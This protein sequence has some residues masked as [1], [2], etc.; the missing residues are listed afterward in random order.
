MTIIFTCKFM[1]SDME[2]SAKVNVQYMLEEERNEREKYF[3]DLVKRASDKVSLSCFKQFFT[4]ESGE[5]ILAIVRSF[6]SP[7]DESPGNHEV[8]F[9]LWIGNEEER[10]KYSKYVSDERWE[11]IG[12]HVFHP[13]MEDLNRDYEEG[14]I[15][16]VE[17]PSTTNEADEVKEEPNEL[18]KKREELTNQLF[19]EAIDNLTYHDNV[20]SE[21]PLSH[22]YMGHVD[23]KND[24][25][26]V[27][28]SP[29]R[30]II[31]DDEGKTYDILIPT[32]RWVCIGSH[33]FE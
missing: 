6:C 17:E 13:R 11:Y 27:Y 15:E 29:N 31:K 32:H 26:Y 14:A 4:L 24:T 19:R 9:Y 21:F 30:L 22:G 23:M 1:N 3:S 8:N 5:Y 18:M 16:L 12:H 20:V 10:E 25:A 33:K 7:D 2:S 28:V